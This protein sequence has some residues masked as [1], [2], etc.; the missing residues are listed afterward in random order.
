M[1]VATKSFD[2]P[3]GVI[4]KGT[5]AAQRFTWEATV[6]GQPVITVRVNWLMGEDEPRPRVD[7]R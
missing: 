3:V 2:T 1:A 5:V 6:K 4:E 7:A